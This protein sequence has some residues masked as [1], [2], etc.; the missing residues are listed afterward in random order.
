MSRL[1]RGTAL[2]LFVSCLLGCAA[3][4]KTHY[5]GTY[6]RTWLSPNG[7]TMQVSGPVRLTLDDHGRY[8]LR[9]DS[10]DTP[11]PGAGKFLWQGSEFTL[12][13]LS[14]VTAGFDLSLILDGTFEAAESETGLIL[15]QENL[16]GDTH[17]LIL[18]RESR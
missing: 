6:V 15:R 14:P 1:V 5:T 16:W 3:G 9:S 2:V 8:E 18:E 10:S 4:T 17:L 7:N 11:P 12:A 13:D